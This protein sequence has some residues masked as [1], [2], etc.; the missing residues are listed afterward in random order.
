M[1]FE[2]NESKDLEYRIYD[3]ANKYVVGLYIQTGD[4]IPGSPPRPAERIYLDRGNAG[5]YTRRVSEDDT[6]IFDAV[7]FTIT[8][9]V[10]EGLIDMIKAL[11][12]PD[13]A[14]P[15]TVFGQT[16]VP[17]TTIGNRI[18][19]RGVSVPCPLPAD[20]IRRNHL[21]NL[22]IGL[23]PPPGGGNSRV[24]RLLGAAVDQYTINQDPPGVRFTWTGMCYGAMGAQ[25]SFPAGTEVV[26]A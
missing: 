3:G 18:N 21:V 23:L 16:F 11:G 9:M 1:A 2:M 24:Q 15:W 8:F 5:I 20:Y 14:S 12:N 6:R 26:P 10:N 7:P 13:G 22:Y 4:A 25:N 19:G 17:V